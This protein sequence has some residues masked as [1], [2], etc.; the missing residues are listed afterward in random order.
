MLGY[1]GFY[2]IFGIKNSYLRYGVAVSVFAGLVLLEVYNASV[3]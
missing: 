1:Y 3:Y 2:Q